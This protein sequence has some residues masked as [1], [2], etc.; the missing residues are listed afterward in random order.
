MV[1]DINCVIMPSFYFIIAAVLQ[2]TTVSCEISQPPDDSHIKKVFGD[3]FGN[4]DDNSFGGTGTVKG[5][6][7]QLCDPGTYVAPVSLS[8][9][10][11]EKPRRQFTA[12]GCGPQGLDIE[13]RF[14]LWRCCNGHD[15]CYSI[16]GAEFSF[17]ESEFSSC[18]TQ[19][20]DD[21]NDD[22]TGSTCQEQAN[23]FSKVTALFGKVIHENTQ[24]D[25]TECVQSSEQ[26]RLQW[27]SFLKDMHTEG[28][29]YI[30]D[31]YVELLLAE[32]DGNEGPLVYELVKDFGHMFVEK[33][34][35]VEVEFYQGQ[36]QKNEL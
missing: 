8:S 35:K 4:M 1:S 18:M 22:T 15:V 25:V 7:G 13:E 26:A 10:L 5:L 23:G 24:R 31:E 9:L 32:H 14:G 27:R 3:I 12:N 36:G 6:L 20:C 29:V 34:G 28:G 30:S 16:P 19:V 17:C 2:L 21:F 33:T 11:N